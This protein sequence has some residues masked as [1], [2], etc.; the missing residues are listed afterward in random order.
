M[1][2]KIYFPVILVAAMFFAT[3]AQA[4]EASKRERI[5]FEPG[6][7]VSSQTGRVADSRLRASSTP[8]DANIIGVATAEENKLSI[9]DMLQTDGIAFV[10]YNDENGLI[11]KG[12]FVTAS[13]KSGITKKATAQGM[14]LGVALED[15]NPSSKFLKVRILIQYYSK[16]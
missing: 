12:D 5:I 8:Y 11:K 13:S 16:Q 3:V 14:V 15:A 10:R 2:K 9:Y 1:K 6:T 7:I 4:Q